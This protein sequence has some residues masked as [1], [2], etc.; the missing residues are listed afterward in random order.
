MT[1]YYFHTD[2]G[3]RYPD[4]HGTECRDLAALRATA[5]ATMTQMAHALSDDFWNKESLRITVTDERGLT[6]MSLDLV[7]TVSTAMPG[8][9]LRR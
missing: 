4:E 3:R 5:L 9:R 2:D 1:R 8:A 7:A 6:L